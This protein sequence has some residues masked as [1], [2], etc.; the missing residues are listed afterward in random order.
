MRS[1]PAARAFVL[2][3]LIAAFATSA[4]VASEAGFVDAVVEEVGRSET[5]ESDLRTLCDEIG[6]RQIGSDAMR[7]AEHWAVE[8]FRAAGVDSVE[9]ESFEIPLVWSEG[10]TRIEVLAPAP[11]AVDAASTAWAPPTR[12]RGIVA[13]VLDARGGSSY[14]IR[15]LGEKAA[16]KILLVELDEVKTFH[17]LGVEQRDAIIAMREAAEV[18]A[19][20]VLFA[21]TRPNRLLYRHVN[22]VSGEL[23]PLPSAVLAREDALRLQRLL[24]DGKEVKMRVSLPNRAERGRAAHNV[25]AEIRGS[26]KPKEIVLLGAHL[27]SWDLGTGCLDNAVNVVLTIEAARA[28]KATRQRPRRTIRF[29]LFGAEEA[30]LLGSLAYVRAHRDELD[31]YSAVVVHDM[32]LGRVEGYALSGRRELEAPLREA[33]EP[34]ARL[35]GGKHTTDAFFGSDHFDFLL[36]GVPALIALQDTSDY[37]LSYHSEADTYDKVDLRLLRERAKLAAGAVVGIAQLEE[38]LGPRLD[39][40]QV[41]QLLNRTRLDD[42]MRFLNVWAPWESGQRGREKAIE[43]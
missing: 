3:A 23:D 42:Q 7:R 24:R 40:D 43:E 4:V 14:Q 25:V 11:F 15:R 33:L 32:G 13:E 31:D 35:S 20:A 17:G 9:L 27:D 2:P 1:S 21:S 12:K 6:P 19:A 16:G 38:K 18:G 34:V 37:A 36:E 22:T 26:E 29:V 8:R 5:L 28:I 30:G 10:E 39:R 41:Q